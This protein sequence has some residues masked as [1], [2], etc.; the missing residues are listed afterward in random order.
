M[1]W[2]WRIFIW[3]H[4]DTQ[5]NTADSAAIAHVDLAHLTA[6]WR[7]RNRRRHRPQHAEAKLP[8][9]AHQEQAAGEPD[10]GPPLRHGDAEQHRVSAEA[11]DDG[12]VGHAA[13]FAHCL[14]TV[15]TTGA[16]KLVQQRG[17]KT[18]A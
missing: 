2:W 8:D 6:W 5:F 3:C 16:L 10:N 17:H 7:R 11:F 13:A 14:Q 18:C 12:G 4:H 1:L 9:V 15:A